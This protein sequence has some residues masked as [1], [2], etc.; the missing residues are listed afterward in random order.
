MDGISISIDASSFAI[1]VFIL[2]KVIQLEMRVK[3][4]EEMLHERNERDD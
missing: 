3:R 4:I 2:Y 1:L